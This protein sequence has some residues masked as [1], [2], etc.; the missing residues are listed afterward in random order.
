MRVAKTL[1]T[2]LALASAGPALAQF[3]AGAGRAEIALT[4]DMLPIDNFTT[5]LDPLQARVLLLDSA[6]KRVAIAVIDQTSIGGDTVA[7]YKAIVAE[8]AKVDPANIWIV[9]SHS[10]SAPHVFGGRSGG[11]PPDQ[12][13]MRY[14]AALQGALRDAAS[15]AAK[16]LRAAR[17][18]T[19]VGSS[20]I[21]VNRN[22]LTSEG[23]WHGN[24]EAGQSDKSVRLVRIEGADKSPIAVLL[25]YAVQSSVM[26]QTGGVN[27]G[28]GVTSDLGGAAVQHIEQQL[29]GK[30]VAMF[31]TGAAGDQAPHAK[32]LRP[33]YDKDG[34]FQ[35]M[36]PLANGYSFVAQQ[37][38][39]LGAEAVRQAGA[40]K[41]AG[42][43]PV[44]AVVNGSVTL[45]AQDR[46]RSL[47]QIK[48]TRS[49]TYPVKGK[50]EAPYSLMR[51]GDIV[52][53]GVQAE[54]NAAT[55]IAIQRRSPF[56]QTLV[57]T[58]VNGAAKYL[59]DAS[60]YRDITYQAM[61]SSYAPGGAELLAD[62]IVADLRTL[63]SAK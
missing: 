35:Q 28:K 4:A 56:K 17:V 15:L 46:P 27:G 30:S 51:I 3:T 34:K 41:P 18:G 2:A 26:D 6:G 25:N 58:M 31:L 20:D 43:A 12:G 33:V 55:G 49:Y 61:N 14:K 23:W 11:P 36:S 42:R 60:G 10:F 59:P 16:S 63:K 38:G 48:P 32:A 47:G 21:N 50:A 62:R 7:E 39:Q 13:A 8:Q 9:A 37:G 44:L 54:L 53:V 22:V 19:S 57:V 24:N 52:L 5:I 40:V 45:D 1:L 29:G